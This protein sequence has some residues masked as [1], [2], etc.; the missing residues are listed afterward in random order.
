[1][2]LI[3]LALAV[4]EDLEVGLP[5][6]LPFD[7]TTHAPSLEKAG[8]TCVS[9]HPVGLAEQT[10]LGPVAPSQEPP[11]PRSICHACHLDEVARA[12]RAAQ[13]SC[14]QCHADLTAIV[15]KSHGPGWVES[16]AAEARAWSAS[17]SDCHDDE[18]CFACHEDRGP[19][20]RNPHGPGFASLHGIE[21][22]VDPVSCASCHAP[23]T[24]STCHDAGVWPW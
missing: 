19:L 14:G 21:A 24:C 15:P 11:P 13:G 20:S 5:E 7:H 23:T 18:T 12:P 16:H 3:V 4:A 17:C 10:E 9:C 2:I 8:L 1:M 22:R 6:T